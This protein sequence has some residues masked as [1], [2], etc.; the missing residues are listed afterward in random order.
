MSNLI[1]DSGRIFIDQHRARTYLNNYVDSIQIS[2]EDN[3][4]VDIKN[5]GSCCDVKAT[6]D[7]EALSLIEHYYP[8]LWDFLKSVVCFKQIPTTLEQIFNDSRKEQVEL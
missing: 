3:R 2:F 6:L 1:Y 8:D 5:T 7:V 4:Y